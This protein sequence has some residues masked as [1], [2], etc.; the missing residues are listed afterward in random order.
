MAGL[1]LTEIVKWGMLGVGV[2]Y[3][4]KQLISSISPKNAGKGG[5]EFVSEFTKGI[6]KGL[7][8]P[9]AKGIGKGAETIYKKGVKPVGK[10]V[11]NKGIKPVAKIAM[12]PG[13]AIINV[14]KKPL[15]KKSH[16]ISKGITKMIFPFY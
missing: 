16:S 10:A 9:I 3:V 8:K 7:G 11:F 12:N 4:G 14:V 6:W 1:D 2:Y 13:G 5:A 15:K